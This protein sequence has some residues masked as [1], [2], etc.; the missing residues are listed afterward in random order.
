MASDGDMSGWT[1]LLHSSSKL[2]EQAAPSA[3][4]PPLQ[5]YILHSFELFVEDMLSGF[6]FW[7]I[8]S[9]RVL[10]VGNRGIWISWRLCR[11]SSRRKPYELKL[12]PNLLRPL[13]RYIFPFPS[14]IDKCVHVALPD[15]FFSFVHQLFVNCRVF[16]WNIILLLNAMRIQD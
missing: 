15:F 1:D 16:S 11:R 7:L 12:P 3:Q 13:G 8:V 2:I 4:F 9:Y 14:I 6:E 10:M 5:V